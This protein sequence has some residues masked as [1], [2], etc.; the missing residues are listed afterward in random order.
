MMFASRFRVLVLLAPFTLAGCLLPFTAPDPA[1]A[2][3]ARGIENDARQFYAE[4]AAAPPPQCAYAANENFYDRLHSAAAALR[5]HLAQRGASPAAQRAGEAMLRLSDD[6]R[7]SHQAASVRLD[8]Q[9]GPCMAPQA[10]ALNAD[11]VA[12]A[13]A[14]VVSANSQGGE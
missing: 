11:A 2:D 5:D 9:H 1:A 6:V 10:I 12:R 14:A 8:D 4:L 3:L 7:A 13:A